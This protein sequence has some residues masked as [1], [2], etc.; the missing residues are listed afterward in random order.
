MASRTNVLFLM[1]LGSLGQGCDDAGREVPPCDPQRLGR[2]CNDVEDPTG[3]LP[4]W[5]EPSGTSS[6]SDTADAGGGVT[7]ES[8][9]SG[10]TGGTGDYGTTG[11]G[12]SGYG[13]GYSGSTGYSDSTGYGS[14]GYYAGVAPGTL[15]FD[16]PDD[17]AACLSAADCGPLR[18]ES[19]R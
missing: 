16:D 5:A 10:G 3:Q 8:D 18:P 7:T 2:A 14:S 9:G 11:Y 15:S 1:S 4:P 19:R 12:S 13:T 17:S 6:A